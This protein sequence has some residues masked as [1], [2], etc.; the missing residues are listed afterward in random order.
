M[1]TRWVRWVLAGLA[2]GYNVMQGADIGAIFSVFI[3]AFVLFK[4]LVDET[5]PVPVKL[6]RGVGRVAV[7]AV[8]AGFIAVQT[9]VS[10][11]GTSVTGIAGT[12]QDAE[13]QGETMELGHAMEFPKDRNAGPVCARIVRLQDGHAEQHGLIPGCLRGGN[14]WGAIGRDPVLDKYFANGAKGT[15]PP[16]SFIRQT[17]GGPYAG[18]LVALIAAWAMAQSFRRQN[19]VF[20]DN[21]RRMIW[22]W[23]GGVGFFVAAVIWRPDFRG[24]FTNSLQAAYASLIRNPTKFLLV[25]SWAI[26]DFVCLRR[27]WI[28]PAI[29]GSSAANIKSSIAQLQSWWKMSAALTADGPGLVSS[30]SPP[31]FWPG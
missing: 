25:F 9:I 19:S 1:L 8:F 10:L 30:P 18:I 23:F 5:G 16:H 20:D 3:A 31:A 17:G 12:G 13:S 24:Y 21:Q 2:V 26:V 27:S 22:F 14:Y 15:P 29:S 7:I 4:T 11:F 28:E 6:A